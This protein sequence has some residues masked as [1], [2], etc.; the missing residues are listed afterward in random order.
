MSA[1]FNISSVLL[2]LAA[3]SLPLW[4][5]FTRRHRSGQSGTSFG[6]CSLSLLMQIFEIRHRVYIDDF[7]AIEDTLHAVVLA[8]MIL[9]CIALIL[10]IAA[11]VINNLKH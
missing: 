3:W 4:S 11:H 2:G 1:F 9:L 5:I 7:S 6:L 8:A 10:N